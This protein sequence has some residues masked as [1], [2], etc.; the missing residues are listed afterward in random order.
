MPPLPK[1]EITTHP[2]PGDNACLATLENGDLTPP[3]QISPLKT[4]QD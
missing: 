3:D 4:F 2:D 1:V